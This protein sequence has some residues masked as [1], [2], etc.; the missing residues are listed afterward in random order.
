MASD[1]LIKLA[2]EKLASAVH[3]VS[4][5]GAGLSAESGIAT[6]RDSSDDAALWSKFDPQQLASQEG[7]RAAPEMVIDWYNWR[8][9]TLSGAKPNNAHRSLASLRGWWHITQN[10]D[11]LLEAAGADVDRVLHL[12]GS[13]TEDHCNAGCGYVERIDLS[14][15]PKLRRCECGSYMR[16]SVV[17]FGEA[18]PASILQC[19]MIETQKADLMLVIGTSAQ[20]YPAAGLIESA[21]GNGADII[22]VNT[23]SSDLSGKHVI[24]LVGPAGELLPELIQGMHMK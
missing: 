20:V 14:C 6:F 21:L 4:F 7:F 8:R 1:F 3:P 2:A 10:V 11:N 18:L 17:W 23:E 19:A 15:A 16:P 22:V 24:E 13:L 9:Q 12:H 5:S